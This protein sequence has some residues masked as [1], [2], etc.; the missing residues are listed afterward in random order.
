MGF[1]REDDLHRPIGVREDARQPLLVPE[2]QRGAL[3]GREAT[4][5]ADREGIRVE[6]PMQLAQHVG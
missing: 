5:E 4:R 6:G 2:E 1:A 3:V